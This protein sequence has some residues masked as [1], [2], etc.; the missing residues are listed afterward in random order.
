MMNKQK[1]VLAF[2]VLPV[3]LLSACLPSKKPTQAEKGPAAQAKTQLSL[4]MWTFLDPTKT[5]GRETALKQIVEGYQAKTGI[6]VTVEPQA[7]DTLTAKF[8]AAHS[9]GN[10]PDL[11]WVNSE[12]MG[13]ALKANALEPFE[14][15]FM[16]DW[17]DAEKKDVQDRFWEYGAKDGKHY[18]M[19]FSRNYVAILYRKDLLK[20]AGFSV[21]LKNW[22]EFRAAAKAM[23]VQKDE[24]T[25][26]KRYGF[27]TPM[28]VDK[29]NPIIISNML[30]AEYGTMFNADGTANWAN[31]TGVK[32]V[33]LMRDMMRIDGSIPETAL[34]T[35]IDDLCTDFAAGKYAMITGPSVRIEKA[36]SEC[37]F[38]PATI[39]I[40]AYPS[41]EEGKPSPAAIT[42]WCVGVWSGGKNKEEAGDFLEYMFQPPQDKLWVEIGGQ[43]PMCQSTLQL[44]AD[45]LKDPNKQ[46][47]VD[48]AWCLTNAAW[49]NPT[50][51]TVTAWRDDQ[52]QVM[53]DVLVN[54]KA[55]LQALKDAEIQFNQ[56]NKR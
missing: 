34:T 10:A 23:T 55:P 1:T 12:D 9:A 35:N 49:A 38:D 50:E 53:Q 39:G 33:E 41:F 17:T 51:Y 54:N 24:I 32:A 15:L 36:Q 27:G 47:V 52:A 3:L 48:S 8:L 46:F 14:N 22:D 43:V 7:W 18:Q 5:S 40:M 16:K 21:P 25:G 30:L 31:E 20:A 42:G 11:I 29:S 13:G 6:T 26:L 2:L 19:S 44:C 45:F 37:V 56:R 4:R 28:T